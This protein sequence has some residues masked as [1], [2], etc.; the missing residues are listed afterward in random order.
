MKDVAYFLGS[1]LDEASIASRENELLDT[2]F[3][4]L[5]KAP[6]HHQSSIDPTELITEWRA[7]YPT[8]WT[9]FHRFLKGWCPTHWKL[10]SYSEQMAKKVIASLH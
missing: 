7:L 1:C 2:Y 9:D 6:A 10:N 4:F 3:H 8:A 5:T